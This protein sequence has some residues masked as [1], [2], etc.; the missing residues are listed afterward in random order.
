MKLVCC[1]RSLLLSLLLT[2]TSAFAAVPTIKFAAPVIY[3]SGGKAANF[4]VSADV[5]GDGVPDMIVSN[6]DGVSV[7]INNGDGTFQDPVAYPTG[8]QNAF[9]VAVADLNADGFADLV[10]TNM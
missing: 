5:D 4:V 6:T 3:N 1:R 9:A 10:V 8:G 7:M 2:V